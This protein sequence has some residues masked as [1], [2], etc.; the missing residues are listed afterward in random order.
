MK[1]LIALALLLCVFL[2]GA[3]AVYAEAP[4]P[5]QNA[6]SELYSVEGVYIDSVGNLD[7]YSFHVPQLNADSQD[8]EEINREIQE[9]FG[10]RIEEQ[11]ENM[12]GGYSLW[13]WESEWHSYWFGNQLF[14]LLRAELEGDYTDYMAYGYDFDRECRITNSM[15]LEE[16]GLSEEDYLANLREKVQLMAEDKVRGF[17]EKDKAALGYDALLQK[18]M[19]WQTME[20]PMYIDGSGQLITIVKI[21][22]IAGAEWYYHLATPYAYG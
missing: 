6:V 19:E 10:T 5:V 4:T 14:L 9:R 20:A 13:C 22:S 11:F 1:R 12:A 7:A 18:T 16:L 15:V 17:S 8:A 3:V 2:T 21:A